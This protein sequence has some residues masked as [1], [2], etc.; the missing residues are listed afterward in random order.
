MNRIGIC[1]L[2]YENSNY[3]ANLQAYALIRII[4]SL[5][6]E[7]DM[8]SYYYS[9]QLRYLCRNLKHSFKRKSQVS[10]CIEVREKAVKRFN[11]AIPHSRLFYSNTIK[12]S[13][14][15][16]DVFI[17]GSD[18]VWNPDWINSFLA[19]DFVEDNKKTISYAAS[20][21]KINL[22]DEQKNKLQIAI[23]NTDYISI[24]EKESIQS[25]QNL[26]SKK[27]EYVL[28]PTMLLN[29]SEWDEICSNRI[30]LEDYL[31]CYFLG[32]NEILRNTAKE[33]AKQKG[34]KIVN[35]PYM[36][37]ANQQVDRNFGDYSLSDV[38][39]EDFLSLIRYASFVITDSFHGAVFAHIYQRR[40]IVSSE[41][42]NEMGCRMQSLVCL[43]GTENRY[44]NDHNLVTNRLLSELEDTPLEFKYEQYEKMKNKSL[45]FLKE[46][47]KSVK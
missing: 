11:N 35:I 44:I 45:N 15:E 29:K 10:K 22:N 20:I 25:L 31:F 41:K 39:P 47:L 32:K 1:T 7:A 4:T 12:D 26:T 18:Q 21:G 42:G 23:D 5:G 24:R 33:Y 30:V 36:N 17:T 3:G 38:S 37:E 9:N 14:N 6:Y 34:L 46:S 2:Y 13:N 43:F 28:D 8:I 16:Y 19:L 27:I 40:F